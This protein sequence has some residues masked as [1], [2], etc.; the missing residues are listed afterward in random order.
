MSNNALYRMK[1]SVK[2]GT[3]SLVVC[4]LLAAALVA[5]NILAGLLPAKL[6]K[7]DVSGSGLTSVSQQTKTFLKGMD[8]DV[9]IYWLVEEGMEDEPCGCSSAATPRRASIL[10]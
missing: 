1:R 8:E 2:I 4:L 3:V 9:T 7:F 5:V 10:R 6:S